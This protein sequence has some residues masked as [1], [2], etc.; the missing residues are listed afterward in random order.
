VY[1]GLQTSDPVLLA[2]K[3]S[4]FAP[5]AYKADVSDTN[6]SGQVTIAWNVA[7]PVN[8]YATYT[9]G[10]K[11]VGLNLN[12]LPTDALG[13]PVLSTALVKPE[14]VRNVEV[15]VKTTL[16]PGVTVNVAVYDTQIHDYQVQVTN[17]DVRVVRGYLANAPHVRV[18]GAEIDAHVRAGSH[19]SIYGAAAYTDGRYVSFPD[20]PPPLE[21]TGGPSFV[22]ISGSVLPGF[23]RW[24]GSVGVNGEHSATIASRRGAVFAAVDTSARSWFSSSATPSRYLGVDGYALANARV[25]FRAAAGWTLFFWVRNLFDTNYFELLS[26]APGNTGLYVGQPGDARTCGATLRLTLFSK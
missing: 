24:V 16:R 8:A 15:G 5:Q 7:E 2:L 23:S 22:D 12:G 21:A 18:R 3:Q 13:R 10:F 1:G 11:S 17:G 6:T 9:T 4:V 19:L 14:N 20:A 25:G 26:A